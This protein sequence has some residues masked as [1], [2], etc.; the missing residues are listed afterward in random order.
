MEFFKITLFTLLAV[1]LIPSLLVVA[2]GSDDEEGDDDD[3][4]DGVDRHQECLD[5]IGDCQ[6]ATSST[7]DLCPDDEAAQALWHT[8]QEDIGNVYCHSCGENEDGDSI[9]RAYSTGEGCLDE[10]TILSIFCE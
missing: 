7:C 3:D 8:A 10:A 6:D 9:M 2:C 4:D 5:N 1:I